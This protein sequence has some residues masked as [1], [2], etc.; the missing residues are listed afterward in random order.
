MPKAKGNMRNQKKQPKRAT[1]RISRPSNPT[2]GAVST[3]TTAPVAIGN[4]MRGARAQVVQT[5]LDQCRVVGRDYAQTAQSSGTVTGWV[6]V[7]GFPLTPNCF[8][9]S[10]LRNYCQMYN[11]YKFNRVRVHYITSSPTSSS[12]DVL[13][14]VNANRTDPLPNWTG[15]NFLPYALSKPETVI[16]PQWTNHTMEIIPKGPTR[17]LVLGSNSDIDYQSQGE[18]FLYSKTSTTDSPGY[19]LIDYDV[20]FYEQSVNPKQ[21]I[22][23]NQNLLWQPIQFTAATSSYTTSSNFNPNIGTRWIGGQAIPAVTSSSAF[24]A[25]DIF[26]VVLDVTNTNMT[27]YTVSAGTK[28]TASTLFQN[29]AA[30]AN[31]T[32][33]T[34]S[35]GFTCYVVIESS[36]NMNFFPN[37]ADAFTGSEPLKWG[38]ANTP[39]AYAET[40][41]VPSAGVWLFAMCSYVGNANSAAQQQQ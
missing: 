28:P 21:G 10:V 2:F 12:G 4:S 41:G 36:G 25:N 33:I 32:A 40:S 15:A 5:G 29:S 11:K 14:Q 34:V 13:F 7:A 9:S 19:L 31:Q 39:N 8:V 37:A 16:G 1:G 6:P 23:P 27:A 38:V 24:K 30:V 35:D 17:T 3:V 20:T 22:L 26:K 18:V